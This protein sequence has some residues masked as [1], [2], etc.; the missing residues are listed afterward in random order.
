MMDEPTEGDDTMWEDPTF[1]CSEK[2]Y[3]RH[4]E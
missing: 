3:R 1:V 2:R 4:P